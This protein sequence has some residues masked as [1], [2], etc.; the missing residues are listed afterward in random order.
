[1]DP[2]EKAEDVPVEQLRSPLPL[3][4]SPGDT[5]TVQRIA[6]YTISLIQTSQT[7]HSHM[8]DV[9]GRC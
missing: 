7:D 2:D 4:V 8:Y 5:A 1:M 6:A 9:P 3:A